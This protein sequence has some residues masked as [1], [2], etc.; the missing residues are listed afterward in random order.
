MDQ[1]VA[2]W[3]GLDDPRTGNAALHD[4]HKLLMIALCT[5]LS[6]GQGAVDMAL[7]AK[8]K[9]PVLRRFLKLANG[10]PSHDTFRRVN[11]IDPDG[12]L[13]D[14]L[15]PS[16]ALGTRFAIDVERRID[17]AAEVGEHK[18]SML[19]DLERGRPMEIDALLGAVVELGGV[20]GR[21][22]PMCRAII[23]ALVRER[24]RR[25]GCY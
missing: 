23:L 5:V 2:C 9:K 19:Q 11:A 1:F 14:I 6:G 8:A 4:F 16:Q 20:V 10:V 25:A 21:E 17:G 7:F 3:E 24:A 15:P 12:T 18:T 13:W 22:M